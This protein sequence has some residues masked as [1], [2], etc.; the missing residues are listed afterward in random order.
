MGISVEQIKEN[1]ELHIAIIDKYLSEDRATAVKAMIK[2][3]GE[4]EYASAP[5]SGKNWYHGAYPGGYIVHVN[6]VVQTVITL[7]KQ[8]KN[9]GGTLDFDL[10]EIVF[11]ALFHDLGKIADGEKVNYIAN[12]SEWHV[13][14]Q[15][16]VYVSNPDL[17]FM[18]VPDRS[19]FLLQKFGIPVSQQEYLAIKLHDGVFDE[20]NKAY[21]INYKPESRFKSNIVP[22]LHTADYLASRIEFDIERSTCSK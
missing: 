6:K 21:Y 7:C 14:N 2:S 4:E 1:Y 11:S 22:I 17:D 20:S 9:L 12:P 13:K 18:L 10:E 5:A 3:L 16:A 19:L 8:Y 15:G